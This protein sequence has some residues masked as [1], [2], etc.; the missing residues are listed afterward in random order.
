[1]TIKWSNLVILDSRSWFVST[2]KVIS[3]AKYSIFINFLAIYC[4]FNS[5]SEQYSL[6]FVF[7]FNEFW[8]SKNLETTR[9]KVIK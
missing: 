3:Y 4:K 7:L 9:N 8:R 6:K 2:C 5:F 1:M